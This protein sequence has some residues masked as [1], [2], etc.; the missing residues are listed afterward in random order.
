MTATGYQIKVTVNGLPF[1]T[2]VEGHDQ[3]H[4]ARSVLAKAKADMHKGLVPEKQSTKLVSSNKS[5][6]HAYDQTWKFKWSEVSKD[7]G[8][9]LKQY[10]TCA[11]SFFMDELKVTRVD[12][13]TTKNIDEYVVFLKSVKG[14]SGSTVN[15]KLG[16]LSPILKLALH[17]GVISVLP[18]LTWE[19]KGDP[20][21]RYYT[22]LEE[23]GLLELC[24][25]IDF[26]DTDINTLLKDFTKV[27]FATGMRPWME[28]R[29]IQKSWIRQDSKG[30]TILTVPKWASKTNK[31]R[32]IPITG[33]ALEVVWRRASGLERDEQLFA[34]L[35]Y[36]WHCNRFWQ[37]VV[38]PNMGWGEDEVWYGIRHTFATR[39]CE[40]NVNLKTVQELMGHKNIN[41]TA[42]YAKATDDAKANAIK[43]LSA[44]TGHRDGGA[45]SF[46]M[47]SNAKEITE[48]SFLNIRAV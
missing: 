43:A 29:N 16:L 40:L 15:N 47:V 20:R 46:Q 22:H 26:H 38:R 21:L 1:N 17:H 23:H 44:M 45:A 10:W 42:Q 28:A 2:F 19:P 35:D 41:Q 39:L 3:L 12:R 37:E 8:T 32:S 30:N 9:K 5:L 48:E 25:L 31:E 33:D 6:Q 36:K 11:S 18:K 7:Y 24:D 27:L 14:N 13:L 4:E 34:R